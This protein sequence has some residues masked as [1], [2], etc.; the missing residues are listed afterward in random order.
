MEKTDITFE[1]QLATW[2]LPPT[3]GTLGGTYTGRFQFRC[4]LD[5]I[6]TLQ[7]GR[8]YREL[9]GSL[10]IQAEDTERELAWALIQL[11]HRVILSPPFWSNTTQSDGIAGNVGDLNI[12]ALVMDAAL[13]AERLYIENVQKE[14]E[15]SLNRS[16]KKGEDL[17]EKMSKGE[18]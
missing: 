3:Q 14:R 5:P 9:L 4:W 2:V 8:E 12:I 7:A 11:K 16:I 13:R 18:N 6:R 1:G 10:A 17:L 15:E